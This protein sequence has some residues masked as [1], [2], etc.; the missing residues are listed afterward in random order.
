MVVAT[1]FASNRAAE[2]AGRCRRRRRAQDLPAGPRHAPHDHRRH[3]DRHPD[4]FPA[5]ISPEEAAD[6]PRDKVMLIV[7]GS[8]ANVAASAQLSRGRYLGIE[9]QDGDSFL[10]S[11]RTIPAT[12]AASSAS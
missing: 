2:N 1:T 3:R 5:V 12:N 11:S 4:R 9:L 6:L 10:F 8:R 7:T